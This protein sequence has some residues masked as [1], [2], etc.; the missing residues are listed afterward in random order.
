MGK[1]KTSKKNV[2]DV[3]NEL[4]EGDVVF[5]RTTGGTHIGLWVG[6]EAGDGGRDDIFI[7]RRARTPTEHKGSTGAYEALASIIGDGTPKEGGLVASGTVESIWR[8]DGET[9][10]GVAI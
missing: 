3:L 4:G 9:W 10:V 6:I 5:L 2:D 8:W 7:L 1:T